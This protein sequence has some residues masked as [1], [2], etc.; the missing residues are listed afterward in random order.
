MTPISPLPESVGA[1]ASSR[2]IRIYKVI[3]D[4]YPTYRADVAVLFGK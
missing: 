1:K 2:S 4:G 3:A